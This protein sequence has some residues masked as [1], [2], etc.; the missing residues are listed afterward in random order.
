MTDGEQLLDFI[1]VQTVAKHLATA[2]YRKDIIAGNP[3]VVNIGSGQGIS[4]L[5]FA[6]RCWTEQGGSGA[7][8][9]GVIP[10]RPHQLARMVAD[11]S[12]LHYLK[13]LED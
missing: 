1:E 9:P 3:F 7:L 5:E 11:T 8:K 2:I 10:N 6:K 12:G 13:N 4:V